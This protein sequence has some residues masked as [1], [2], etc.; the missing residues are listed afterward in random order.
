ML[1]SS[2]GGSFDAQRAIMMSRPERLRYL[3][4]TVAGVGGQIRGMNELGQR[5]IIRQLAQTT[6]FDVGTIRQFIDKGVGADID[7]LIQRSQS[8]TA[9]TAEEQKRAADQLTTRRERQQIISDKLVNKNTVALERLT[10]TLTKR[11]IEGQELII[12][13]FTTAVGPIL[14]SLNNTMGALNTTLSKGIEAKVSR[15]DTRRSVNETVLGKPTT[16][17]PRKQ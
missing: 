5:A 12:N 14:N 6:G 13:K 2:L 16:K 15:A 4:E 9:M 17:N 7:K 8:L 11:S 10:E 3:A 1:L